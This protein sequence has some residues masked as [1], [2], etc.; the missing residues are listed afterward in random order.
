VNGDAQHLRDIR[1]RHQPVTG[2]ECHD[3]PF[4]ARS[5]SLVEDAPP[6]SGCGVVVGSWSFG[7]CRLNETGRVEA[8]AIQVLQPLRQV[9]QERVVDQVRD[10]LGEQFR[11]LLIL[12]RVVGTESLVESVL[13]SIGLSSG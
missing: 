7:G 11:P 12:K 10:L 6:E 8:C 13:P 5:R 3:H 4:S 1:K 2:L 9:R